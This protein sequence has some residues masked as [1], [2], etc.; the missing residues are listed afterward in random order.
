[1]Q[2]IRC[3]EIASEAILGQNRALVAFPERKHYGWQNSIVGGDPL[4]DDW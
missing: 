4:K 1:M 2:E 3:T